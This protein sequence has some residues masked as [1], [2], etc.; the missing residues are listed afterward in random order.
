M[1]PSYIYFVYDIKYF[2]LDDNIDEHP[3]LISKIWISALVDQPI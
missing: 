2:L 3:E 1:A